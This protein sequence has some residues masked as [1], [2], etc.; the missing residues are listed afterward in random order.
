METI[1]NLV[2]V[3]AITFGIAFLDGAL[4]LGMSDGAYVLLGLVMMV[5]IVWMLIAVHKKE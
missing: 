2:Y 1:K 3:M 5:T 4:E